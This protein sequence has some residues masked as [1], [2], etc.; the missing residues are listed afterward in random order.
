MKPSWDLYFMRLCYLAATR[1]TCDR[2]HVGSVI[3]SPDHRV[4]ATGYNG[5]PSG[6]DT[7][8]DVGHE[9]VEGHCVRSLHSESNSIDYAGRVARGCSLYVTVIP[10]YDCC[11]RAVNAGIVEVI[12]DEFYA[13]RYGKS[14]Q[15]EDFFRAA[16]V[17]IRQF[18][19]P[20]LRLFKTKL[21]EMES[22]ELEALKTTQVDFL[23]GSSLPGNEAG[24]RCKDHGATRAHE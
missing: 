23:C 16:G 24:A 6:C 1:A 7:C 13:S 5:A 20:G 19:S 3:V 10:C 8:D 17:T 15:V 9:I 21:A 18:D 14:S 2:K 22:L 11:K 4:V 12:Y